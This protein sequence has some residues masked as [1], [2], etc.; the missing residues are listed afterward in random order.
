MILRTLTPADEKYLTPLFNRSMY[1]DHFTPELVRENVYDDENFDPGLT[2]VSEDEYGINGFVM[3]VIRKREEADHGYIKLICVDP[4]IQRKGIGTMLLKAVEAELKA[5]KVQFI[6]IYESYPNYYMPGVD[7]FYT[8]AVCFFERSGYRKFG[9]T[10][11]LSAD[12]LAWD[13]DTS[14]EAIKLESEGFSISRAAIDEKDMMLD[15]TLKNFRGWIGEVTNSFKNDPVSLHICKKD[16]RIIAFSAY[17]AN[18][19]G[20]GWFG[21]MGTGMETRGKGIGGILLKRC[22]AD[23]KQL[24]FDKAII[25]WVGPIPFYMHY[26][27][28]KVSRVFWRY[29]KME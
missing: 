23:L 21:P 29:E 19:K 13:F 10:S 9:D 17:E 26:C 6:R 8:E 2:F 3:G 14:A 4:A 20:T 15:W 5:A 22:L 24:G 1:L 27:G 16:G 11:N 18:N 28:S 12:L 25:P 7:P